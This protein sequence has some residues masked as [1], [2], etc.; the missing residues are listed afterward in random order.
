MRV[1][2]IIPVLN[3]EKSIGAVIDAIPKNMVNE[4]VV[5][6][7]GSSDQSALIA[8]SKGAK[9]VHELRR[10]YGRACL[11]ALRTLS[12]P[13]VV[14]FLNGDLSDF[15]EELPQ[16]IAP[17]TQGEADF[18]VGSRI[19]GNWEKGSIPS[20]VL[21]RNR[22]ACLLINAFFKKRYTDVGPFR[23]IRYPVLETLKMRDHSYAWHVEMQL[24]VAK[25]NAKVLEVP[26]RYRKRVGESKLSGSFR[27]RLSASLQTFWAIL[28]F[29]P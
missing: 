24:K 14:V 5:V 1:S 2:I 8:R 19:L 22:L 12:H 21:W 25:K 4:I 10:G 3:E 13:D 28:R 15:P 27:G 16:L 20:Q 23:A 26:V 18:V 9:V 6:D 7:N 11:T 17:I 29:L